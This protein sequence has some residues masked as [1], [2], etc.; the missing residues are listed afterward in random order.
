MCCSIGTIELQGRAVWAVP[1]EAADAP[2]R[3]EGFRAGNSIAATAFSS[4]L[5]GV[6]SSGN[7][8]EMKTVAVVGAS[9]NREKWGNKAVR[10][11]A[12]QGYTVY[13]VNPTEAEVE[14][15]KCYASVK[16]VPMRP[17]MI[18]VYLAPPRLLKVLGDIAAR[19]CDEL[20][21]N[22]GTESPEVLAECAR[23]GLN[24]IQACSIIAVGVS[25]GR[26]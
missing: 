13:P 22:P 8:P 18:S 9:S 4:R 7:V 1:S 5:P 12:Q 24:A 20:F 26:L 19:G 3:N 14:G 17:D 11:F 15:W 2:R 6:N 16:E 21:L 25:P 10:A 23:L